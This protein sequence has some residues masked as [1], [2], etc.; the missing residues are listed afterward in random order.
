MFNSFQNG[1]SSKGRRTVCDLFRDHF[2]KVGKMVIKKAPGYFP[3]QTAFLLST[4]GQNPLNGHDV[5]RM[6]PPDFMHHVA[7]LK[8]QPLSNAHG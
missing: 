5:Q 2:A 3:T 8:A 1:N 7:V 6:Q 4:P